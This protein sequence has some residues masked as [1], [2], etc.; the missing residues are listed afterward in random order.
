MRRMSRCMR[1]LFTF[2]PSRRSATRTFRTHHLG[3]L[4]A[5]HR[6]CA[7][8]FRYP[9]VVAVAGSNAWN[10]EVPAHTVRAQTTSCAPAQSFPE[11][12]QLIDSQFFSGSQS[13]PAGGRPSDTAQLTR[14]LRLDLRFHVYRQKYPDRVP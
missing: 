9:A 11:A 13:V 1:F 6:S 3:K 4:C 14:L 12:R 10:G 8:V 2:Q 5:A 7:S